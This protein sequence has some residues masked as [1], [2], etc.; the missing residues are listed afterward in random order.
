MSSLRASV[1]PEAAEVMQILQRVE[2][3]SLFYSHDKLA[4]RQVRKEKNDLVVPLMT[5]IN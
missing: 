2:I 5:I 4:E 1:L 3:E